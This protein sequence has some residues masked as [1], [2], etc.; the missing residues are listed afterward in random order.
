[1]AAAE[2]GRAIIPAKGGLGILTKVV[3]P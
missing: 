2:G 1:L 3:V